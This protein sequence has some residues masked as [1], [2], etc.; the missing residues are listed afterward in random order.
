MNHLKMNDPCFMEH[1]RSHLKPS[2]IMDSTEVT[3]ENMVGFAIYIF[4]YVLFVIIY[5]HIFLYPKDCRF[6]PSLHCSLHT[7]P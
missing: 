3:Q 1:L 7:I 5:I 6:S 2:I 4:L